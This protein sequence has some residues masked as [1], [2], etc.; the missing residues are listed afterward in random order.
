MAA[1]T[2]WRPLAQ[3]FHG[4][5]QMAWIPSVAMLCSYKLCLHSSVFA[6][7]SGSVNIYACTDLTWAVS[8]PYLCICVRRDSVVPS[9]LKNTLHVAYFKIRT[10]TRMHTTPIHIPAT[11]WTDMI[12]VLY[13]CVSWPP[14]I[15]VV[16]CRLGEKERYD[17]N[18]NAKSDR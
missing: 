1:N 7:V 2:L 8:I 4:V 5:L 11:S 17:N 12:D 6:S 13:P 16:A 3:E 18:N 9:V 15:H 10:R 14:P